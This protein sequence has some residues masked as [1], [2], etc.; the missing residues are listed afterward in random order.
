MFRRIVQPRGFAAIQAAVVS[1]THR[2]QSEAAGE[3]AA[4][5][6]AKPQADEAA[7]VDK[8]VE[9]A[10]KS[11]KEANEKISELKKDILYT[12]AE[13]ENVRRIGREDVE[14]ARNFAVTSFAKDMVEVIDILEKAVEA[15]AK[16]PQEDLE[17]NKALASICT[18]V[19]MSATV[20]AKNLSKHG[21]EKMELA[22]G[23]R[24]DPNRHEALF[25]A[26]ETDSVK[27]EHITAILKPG[28]LLKERVLRAAQ[29]GVAE[30]A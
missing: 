29:I 11:L 9:K 15:F 6:A 30:K 28:Y 2:F 13:T 17:K 14:K 23:D 22:V 26:P 19:K 24:F 25:K 7:T 1:S 18:G 12:A 4:D 8:R 27:E 10:E 16:L 20:L 3:K 5:P 21:V